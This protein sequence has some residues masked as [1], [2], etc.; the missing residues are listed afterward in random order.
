ML[1]AGVLARLPVKTFDA[2]CAPAAYRFVSQA[3][4]IGKV[5]LTIPDGPGGQSGLAGGTVVV[6]GG[7]RHGRFGGG[8]PFGPATWGGQS[9]SG[10]PKR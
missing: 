9:G 3:R 6:T 1:A 8:Y 7:D 4:H 2:R 10:Q 5:V